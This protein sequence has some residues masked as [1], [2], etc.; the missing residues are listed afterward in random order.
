M[1]DLVPVAEGLG[2]ECFDAVGVALLSEGLESV[3]PL[4][5]KHYLKPSPLQQLSTDSLTGTHRYREAST[6]YELSHMNE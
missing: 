5:C 1:A 6:L 4:S 3:F 2:A